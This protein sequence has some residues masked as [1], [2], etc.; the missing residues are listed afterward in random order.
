[1]NEK[2]IKKGGKRNL[3]N[4]Q[5]KKV[6]APLIFVTGVVWRTHGGKRKALLS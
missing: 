1:V 4:R 5:S 3:K 6:H 2:E